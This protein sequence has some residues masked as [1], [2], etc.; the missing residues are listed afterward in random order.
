MLVEA[1]RLHREMH[2]AWLFH[3]SA[4]VFPRRH[5]RLLRALQFALIEPI[6]LDHDAAPGLV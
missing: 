1:Q 6:A 5:E 4:R 3:L 2:G